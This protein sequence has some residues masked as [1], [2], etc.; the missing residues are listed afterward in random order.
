LSERALIEIIRRKNLAREKAG[1]APWTD[2]KQGGR[3]V[4]V[5][6]FRTS[7]RDRVQESTDFADWLAEAALAHASGDKVEAAYK[8]GDALQKRRELMLAWE[9]YC[10]GVT[11]W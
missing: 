11:T 6:G 10:E 4:T 8:R 5:H 2:P 1:L 3:P 9:C 7:F